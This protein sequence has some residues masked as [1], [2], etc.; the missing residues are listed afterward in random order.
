MSSYLVTISKDIVRDAQML[1]VY[2]EKFMKEDDTAILEEEVERGNTDWSDVS[3]DIVLE[4]YSYYPGTAED[5]IK[6]ISK[7]YGINPYF[8]NVY[9]IKNKI[10]G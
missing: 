5:I 6:E 8:I 7:E 3:A 9:E 1:R 4:E 2:D 10:E